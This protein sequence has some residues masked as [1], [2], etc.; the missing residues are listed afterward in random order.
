VRGLFYL[1]AL[2]HVATLGFVCSFARVLLSY[3]RHWPRSS[4]QVKEVGTSSTNYLLRKNL[5]CIF[6][7][8]NYTSQPFYSEFLLIDENLS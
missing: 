5:R 1:R 4:I 8:A 3:T 6:G 7:T 2:G